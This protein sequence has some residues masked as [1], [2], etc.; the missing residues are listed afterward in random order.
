MPAMALR[1]MTLRR[2]AGL[3]AA[4]AEGIDPARDPLLAL[5]AQ[6]LTSPPTRQA[7]ARTIR[8]LLDAAEE[9]RLG[10]RPPL[11]AQD[12]LAARVELLAVAQR[13]TGPDPVSPQAAALAS[14]LV[15]D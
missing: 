9:P 5:R 3:D 6:Q 12:V 1:L 7:I 11:Q 15:W 8:N 14:Q 10:S 2:R 4:L 13:L